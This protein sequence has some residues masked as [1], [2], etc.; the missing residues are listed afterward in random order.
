V[1]KASD[2]VTTAR[3]GGSPPAAAVRHRL[4]AG[5][6]TALLENGDLRY[7]R[8]GDEVILLRVYGA[9]RDRNWDTIEPRFTRYD[10]STSRTGFTVSY[11]AECVGGGVD[12]AWTGTIIGT[13]DGTI[14]CDFDGVARK[15][16]QRNRIGWCV[17]HPMDL[18]GLPAAA[19]TP[20]GLVVGAF[21]E[22]LMP[23]QPFIDMEQF[24]HPTWGGGMVSIAFEGDLFEMEDQRNW[25]DASYKTYSTPLRLAYPVQLAAGERVHQRLRIEVAPPAGAIAWKP[26]A[27]VRVSVGDSSLGRMPK[28]GVG[29]ASHG[30][31]LD[32][33]TRRVLRGLGLSHLRVTI[34]P[35][36]EDW[37]ERY[38]R[39][40]AEAAALGVTV[41]LEV[42]VPDSAIQLAGIAEEI[43]RSR[44]GIARVLGFPE[45]KLTTDRACMEALR[46]ALARAGVSV[47]VG[48]GSR[49][50][51][52]ELNRAEATIPW[53]L[54]EVVGYPM[55]PT[56]HAMDMLSVMETL[57]AQGTTVR[58]ARRLGG[59]KPV[60]VG[61]ITFR[62]PFNPNA[63]GAPT[64]TPEGT[65]P[66]N[67]DPRQSSLAAAAWT[68]GSIGRLARAGAHSLT[69]F[70]TNGW[71]GLMERRDHPLRVPG[72][73][74]WPGMIFP[75][76]SVIG[77]LASLSG[78]EVLPLTSSEEVAIDGCAVRSGEEFTAL[79]ANLTEDRQRVTVQ[80]PISGDVRVRTLDERSFGIATSDLTRFAA[81]GKSHAAEGGM[82]TI[83]LAPY[84]VATLL[85]TAKKRGSGR[86]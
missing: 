39:Q 28:I 67:V 18:A 71:R 81:S 5:P 15:P 80:L 49:A 59:G 36:K 50:F 77:D 69:Y 72:F 27:G 6:V 63:T 9:I 62:M 61:P 70:Q 10:V 16:F 79:V 32:E 82:L 40:C 84:A 11:D 38:R 12:F 17:L 35:A 29:A 33:E 60:A 86:R 2:E 24:V 47:P 75:V 76:A 46:G 26:S 7:V 78:G 31:P 53:E 14:T 41:E 37:R 58:D 1:V 52:T 54:L 85:A 19:E 68:A 66:A 73:A 83:T 20:G 55:N 51:F 44:A 74:S 43:T 56:V 42:L 22:N 23:W 25:T 21:P 30:A 8:L 13:A 34:D 3:L 45:G 4:S 64:P 57:A 65:I 48:G